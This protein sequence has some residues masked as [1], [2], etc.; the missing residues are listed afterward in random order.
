MFDAIIAE[1]AYNYIINDLNA[2]NAYNHKE[3]LLKFQEDFYSKL[4]IIDEFNDWYELSKNTWLTDNEREK[5][6]RDEEKAKQ[7]AEKEKAEQEKAEQEAKKKQ[8]DR[9]DT[10]GKVGKTIANLPN[11]VAKGLSKAGIKINM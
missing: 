10:A 1:A 3:K 6:K 5:A 8:Q 9:L 4:Q 11:T 7:E 2:K